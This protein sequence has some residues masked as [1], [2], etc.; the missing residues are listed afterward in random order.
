VERGSDKHG[1]L[2][3]EEMKEETG[4]L[5][6]GAPV[7]PRAEESRQQEPA[8]E[9]QPAPDARP[10]VTT[11]AEARADLAR[12]LEPSKFPADRRDLI[13]AATE[14][15][16]PDRVLRM[17]AALPPDRSFR[18]VEEVWEAVGGRPDPRRA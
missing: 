5:E 12:R 6:R 17:L 9:D 3:D 2:V 8:G 16:A 4:G 7:E 15:G 13:D 18:T 14:Q 11:E 1:R 10:E